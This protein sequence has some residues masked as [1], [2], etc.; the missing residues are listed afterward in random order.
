MG[1][2]CSE[3]QYLD[4]KG[5]L[6]APPRLGGDDLPLQR[7]QLKAIGDFCNRRPPASVGRQQGGKTRHVGEGYRRRRGVDGCR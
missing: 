1:S 6:I 2:S 4:L 5:L 7:V 3:N